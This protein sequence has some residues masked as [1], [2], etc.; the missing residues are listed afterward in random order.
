MPSGK[1]G[2]IGGGILAAG[3]KADGFMIFISPFSGGYCLGSGHLN[4]EKSLIES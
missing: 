2:N 3:I 1:E 4:D